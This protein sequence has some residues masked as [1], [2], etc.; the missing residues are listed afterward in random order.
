MDACR[1]RADEQLPA[2]LAVAA[3]QP[4]PGGAPRTPGPSTWTRRRPARLPRGLRELVGPDEQQVAERVR[5]LRVAA[6]EL[7]ACQLLHEEAMPSL[8][9]NTCAATI[10]AGVCPKIPASSATSSRLDRGRSIRRTPRTRSSSARNSPSGVAAV[11]LVTAIRADGQH[12]CRAED[13][14]R[15]HGVPPG[16]GG[17]GRLPAEVGR[18]ARRRPRAPDRGSSGSPSRC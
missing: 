3:A 14:G 4:P 8:R 11:D 16:R 10:G 9:W 17:R 18:C 1:L 6:F 13:V 5:Q 12:P 7:D 2:D 15:S